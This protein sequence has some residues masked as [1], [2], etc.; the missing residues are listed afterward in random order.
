MV[1]D[2]TERMGE[3]IYRILWLIATIAILYGGLTGNLVSFIFGVGIFLWTA[4]TWFIGDRE[5][6]EY[7]GSEEVKEQVEG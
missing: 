1:N 4:Y 2:V 3:N 7:E 5:A 6:Q